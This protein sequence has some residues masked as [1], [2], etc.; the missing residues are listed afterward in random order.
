LWGKPQGSV[1]T[2]S[3]AD[4]RFLCSSLCTD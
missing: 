2:C 3:S 1:K 4:I